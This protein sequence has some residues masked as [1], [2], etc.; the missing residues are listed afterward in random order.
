MA[1]KAKQEKA[2]QNFDDTDIPHTSHDDIQISFEDVGYNDENYRGSYSK[3]GKKHGHG[4]YTWPD[5]NIYTGDFVNDFA[6][7][8]GV[9]K[10]ADGLVY[11]GDWKQGKM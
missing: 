4:T 9:Q 6:E 3:D 2:Y 1:K 10:W 11:E 8:K 7:G 5:G